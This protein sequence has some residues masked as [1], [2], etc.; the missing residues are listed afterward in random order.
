MPNVQSQTASLPSGDY[1]CAC[2]AGVVSAL[3]YL[4][5][6]LSGYLLW[7]FLSSSSSHR[8]RFKV[9][10]PF[11]TIFSG[12]SPSLHCRHG[13]HVLTLVSIVLTVQLS[14]IL[15]SLGW[16]LISLYAGSWALHGGPL[17]NIYSTWSKE[18]NA[19][20]DILCHSSRTIEVV[21]LFPS[22]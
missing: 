4:C 5:F 21:F 15:C 16:C 17:I 3:S 20:L 13:L 11:I 18:K 7:P 12:T 8:S 6:L 10:H 19:T 2:L 14:L 9:T 22:K 1:S